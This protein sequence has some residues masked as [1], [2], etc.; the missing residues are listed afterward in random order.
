LS[1][2]PLH[3]SALAREN[4]WLRSL[5]E[6]MAY[7]LAHSPFYKEH[8][9]WAG[10]N[11]KDIQSLDDFRELPFTEKDDLARENQAFLCV[12]DQQVRDIVTTSGTLGDPVAYHLT[13]ADLERLARNEAGS[14]RIAGCTADDTFQLLTTMDKRFMAGLAYFMGVQ[15]LGG[16]IIRSGPG[17]L[18][19]QWESILRFHPTVLIA[20]PSFIPRLIRHGKEQGIDINSTSVKRIICIGEPVR[21]AALQPNLLAQRITTDWN[22]QLFSTYASTEMATAFTECPAGN[23][24]HL[25][26]DMAYIEVLKENGEHAQEGEAGEVV[27][28]PFGIEGMP[29]LRYRTGDICHWYTSPCACGRNTPRL[30]PVIGRRQQL[31]KFKGTSLYPNAIIDELN[32]MKEVSAFI[33]EVHSD[34]LGLDEIIL[35]VALRGENAAEKVKDQMGAKLRVSPRIILTDKEEIDRMRF[36]ENDR[37]PKIFFDKR[38][39]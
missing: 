16:R 27:A 13:K 29:L 18:Q 20:V 19:L 4:F 26:P 7:L 24:V 30:G 22:V 34:E 8:L 31:L 23:G 28:T 14:Y 25:Q 21:D 39:H 6:H 35:R 1:I 11:A 32:T 10:P 33:V 36:N 5:Q 37:K 9:K 15:E 12:P 3:T 38:T 17:A 2:S